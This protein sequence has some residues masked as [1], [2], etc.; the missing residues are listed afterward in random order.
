MTMRGKQLA[1]SH[2]RKYGWRFEAMDR[3]KAQNLLFRR[4][5]VRDLF[6]QKWNGITHI[7]YE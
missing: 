3:L 4:D 1:P 2:P 7:N 6:L 5:N